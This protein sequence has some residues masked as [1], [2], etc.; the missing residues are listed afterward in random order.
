MNFKKIISAVAA[1]AVAVS[2]MAVSAFAAMQSETIAAVKLDSQS[3]ND[4]MIQWPINAISDITSINTITIVG[5]ASVA[6]YCGGGGAIGFDSTDGW[7][8]VDFNLNDANVT[9]DSATGDFTAECDFGGAT[10]YFDKED[11]GI[12]QLGWWWGSGDQT[13]QLNDVLVNGTSVLG[14]TG[15]FSA[16]AEEAPAEDEA[17]ADAATDEV[18]DTADAD[19][20]VVDDAEDDAADEA[21]EVDVAEDTAEDVADDAADEVAV[22]NT[23][24]DTTADST[25]TPAATGNASAAVILSVM[26][27]AGAAAVVAKKRK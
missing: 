27:V 6:D 4:K 9:L 12:I 3:E 17:T 26:A 2:A 20:D 7:K 8:Q 15:S 25:T 22:D 14:K 19:A 16:P 11:G 23:S 13:M 1:A 18:E 10:P 24:V 5:T 21:D